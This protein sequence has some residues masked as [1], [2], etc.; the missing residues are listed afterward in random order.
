M[1][2]KVVDKIGNRLKKI[3][4]PLI[5]VLDEIDLVIRLLLNSKGDNSM[6]NIFS[7]ASDSDYKFILIGISNSVGNKDA[8][9]ILEKVRKNF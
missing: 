3:N 5:L 1:D 8:K 4:R 2:E 9:K 6:S 7:W